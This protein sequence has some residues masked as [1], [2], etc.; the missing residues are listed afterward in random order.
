MHP[1]C[2]TRD[3]LGSSDPLETRGFPGNQVQKMLY[4]RQKG[5]EEEKEK[6][7]E[8]MRTVA[9]SN[10]SIAEGLFSGNFYAH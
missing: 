4:N 9:S 10:R 3:S 8:R 2:E 6:E 1:E 7:K 5:K